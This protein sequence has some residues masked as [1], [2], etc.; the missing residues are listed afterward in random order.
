MTNYDIALRLIADLHKENTELRNKILELEQQISVRRGLEIEKAIARK[1]SLDELDQRLSGNS[2]GC[3]AD[4][5]DEANKSEIPPSTPGCGRTSGAEPERAGGEPD[6]P[7]KLVSGNSGQLLCYE[8]TR[9]RSQSGASH[10]ARDHVGVARAVRGQN[11][12]PAAVSADRVKT[13]KFVRRLDDTTDRLEISCAVCGDLLTCID[14]LYTEVN[15]EACRSALL[16]ASNTHMVR[17]PKCIIYRLK[18]P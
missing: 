8:S 13:L 15:P 17:S 12:L 14:R 10:V 4:R 18:E 2:S 5:A 1:A 3:L 6:S 11:L 7:T 16:A 9:Y